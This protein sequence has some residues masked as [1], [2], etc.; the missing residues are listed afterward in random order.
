LHYVVKDVDEALEKY[1][2]IAACASIAAF[3]EALNNWYIRRS[4][5]RFWKDEKDQ[6]KQTAYN[7][8]YTVLNVMCRV[9][10]PLLPMVTEEIYKGLITV[11]E[12]EFPLPLAGE[13][14]TERSSVASVHLADYPFDVLTQVK[15]DA[16]LQA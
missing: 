14:L 16:K 4:K 7:T 8:L 2:T 10:A 6:D 15:P 13:G 1:D 11:G 12:G 9:A 5:E 3:F